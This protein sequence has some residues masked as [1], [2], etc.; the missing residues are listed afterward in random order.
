MRNGRIRPES[1]TLQTKSKARALPPSH[2]NSNMSSRDSSAHS[3]LDTP[4][5]G[6][7]KPLV[8]FRKWDDEVLGQHTSLTQPEAG[9]Q[10]G[11]NVCYVPSTQGQAGTPSGPASWV[12]RHS[13]HAHS[14]RKRFGVPAG[15]SI[16]CKS[17]GRPA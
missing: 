13:H 6:A 15:V 2:P 3:H 17:R 11:V 5:S 4:Q 10:N 1:L 14:K 8:P 7:V 16:A 9:E 12:T